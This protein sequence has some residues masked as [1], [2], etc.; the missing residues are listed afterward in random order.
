MANQNQSKRVQR[1]PYGLSLAQIVS[2]AESIG[3]RELATYLEETVPHLSLSQHSAD[4]N[5]RKLAQPFHY[6]LR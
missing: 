6:T 5:S 1:L 2:E 4:L 3:L